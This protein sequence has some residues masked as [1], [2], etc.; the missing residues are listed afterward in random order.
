[1]KD[2]AAPPLLDS[3]GGPGQHPARTAW[4]A[5]RRGKVGSGKIT[6]AVPELW[7]KLSVSSSSLLRANGLAGQI[8]MGLPTAL[9]TLASV[10][11]A[12]FTTDAWDAMSV[13]L[14]QYRNTVGD[15]LASLAVLTGPTYAENV[16]YCSA[17]ALRSIHT[18]DAARY[19][20]PLLD[21]DS[22]RLQYEA[23]AGVA[24]FANALPVQTPSNTPNMG[25]LNGPPEAGTE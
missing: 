11:P 25:F 12:A 6:D 5:R 15:G 8:R 10:K 2:G 1:M 22:L 24:S 16:R 4:E 13:A 21:S 18:R 19:L 3:A 7:A 17:H 9:T 23:V 14:C 20:R